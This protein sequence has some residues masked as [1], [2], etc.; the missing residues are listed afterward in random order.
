MV[1]CLSSIIG[2]ITS[3]IIYTV[4]LF[5]MDMGST[6]NY[7]VAMTALTLSTDICWD[8]SNV[9]KDYYLLITKDSMEN[10][11]RKV[12]PMGL[13]L[14]LILSC[15]AFL[16]NI[17]VSDGLVFND[18]FWLTAMEMLTMAVHICARIET[19]YLIV[20]GGVVAINR[21]QWVRSAVNLVFTFIIV[22]PYASEFALV[23]TTVYFIVA[24]HIA[25]VR[26][27]RINGR[28]L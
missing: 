11:V 4:T 23:L 24:T 27:T 22:H 1:Y 19:M 18:G 26:Q 2:N 12:L 10:N 25:Y 21:M 14:V 17:I 20:S 9:I 28:K 6:K 3:L 16:I 13:F 8:A 15:L 7:L 5:K